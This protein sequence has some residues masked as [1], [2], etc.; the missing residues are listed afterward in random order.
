MSFNNLHLS[1]F[2]SLIFIQSHRSLVK[3]GGYSYIQ[4]FSLYKIYYWNYIGVTNLKI[5]TK[6]QRKY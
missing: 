4:K 2:T 6:E 1:L 3:D 5:K